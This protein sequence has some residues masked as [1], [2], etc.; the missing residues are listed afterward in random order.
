MER[1]R[2]RQ[3]TVTATISLPKEY[4]ERLDA[5]AWAERRTRSDYVRRLIE[6]AKVTGELVDPRL[7][8]WR[9]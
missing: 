8:D 2:R 3:A 1:K 6:Q 7:K 9:P 4:L 5:L